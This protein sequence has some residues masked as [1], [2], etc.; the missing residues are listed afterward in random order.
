[1]LI[2]FAFNIFLGQHTVAAQA[3]AA[4]AV[5]V[6]TAAAYSHSTTDVSTARSAVFIKQCR[7][8]SMA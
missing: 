3:L 6:Q 8:W 2:K 4:Q 1:M 5:A 7:R